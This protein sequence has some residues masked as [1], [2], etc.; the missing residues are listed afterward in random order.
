VAD[1]V[2][3]ATTVARV[4]A[5]REAR[6]ECDREQWRALAEMGWLGIFVPER[7]GGMGL[8]LA[9][10]AIVAEG[11]G[12]TLVPEPYTA[13][14][15]LAA[16]AMAGADN[17]AFLI[18][19]LPQIV[20]GKLLP[21]VAWQE[22]ARELDPG[23]I[24]AIAVPFEGGFRLSGT[25]QFIAAAADADAFLVSA[26]HQGALALYWVPRDAAGTQLALQRLADG[27]QSGTLTLADVIVGR[28]NMVASPAVARAALTRALDHA[29][30]VA[31]A[32]LLGVM[33]R[34]LEM[35]LDYMKTRV[36]FGKPIGSFQALQ[37]RAVDLF[38]QKELASAVLAEGLAAIAAGV[39]ATQRAVIAS[40]VKARCSDAALLVTRQAIQLHGAIGFTEDCDVGLYVKRALVQA[41]WLGN[42]T[43]HR[44]RLTRHW[45][46]RAREGS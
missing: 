28:E 35:S 38:I 41:A 7:F 30:I 40:R 27:R 2:R 6:S 15:V 36:Q 9:E 31:G 34:A 29:A 22:R 17:D 44:R 45:R 39:D 19:K 3:R 20:S 26:R 12:R 10:A 42:G 1:Y 13:T 4:R 5:L 16:S 32:E 21:A 14:A 46:D 8:G 25:K 43:A 18:E 23:A 37:H 24:E 11:L 33:S